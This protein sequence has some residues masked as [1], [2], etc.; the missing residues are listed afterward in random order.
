MFPSPQATCFG[1]LLAPILS[2]YCSSTIGWRWTFYIAAIIGA[3]TLAASL[4]LPETFGPILLARRAARLRAEQEKQHQ[5]DETQRTHHTA[6]PPS[7]VAPRDLESTDLSQLLTVVCTRPVRMVVT[8]PIVAATCA[9]LALVYTVF[10]MSFQAFPLVFQ[11]LHGL[12]PGPAGLCYLPIGAGACLSLPVF[13]SWD[14]VLASATAAGK[15]WTARE[16][17]RRLPLAFLGGPMFAASLFWLGWT[18]RPGLTFVVPMLAGLPF[19]FGFMLIF[20]ALLNYLTDAYDFFAASANAA[21]S[22]CRSLLAVVLPLA[23]VPMFNRLEI[24]G[25]CSLLGGLS[26]LMC[27][28]PFVFVWKGPVLRERS[29]FCIALRERRAEMQRKAEEQRLTMEHNQNAEKE[30]MA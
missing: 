3:L 9:Y 20:M 21:A 1:P 24:S 29:P 22:T 18:S 26:A 16:E 2:G 8:E 23:T 13:W 14:H 10:Y 4:F 28:I 7:V 12:A 30:D 6:P 11:R 5:D 27:V 15:P 19:G 17:A 25:A